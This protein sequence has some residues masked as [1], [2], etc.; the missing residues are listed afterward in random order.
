MLINAK[1]V[2]KKMLQLTGIKILKKSGRTI[3]REQKFLN[4]SRQMSKLTVHGEQKTE[5]EELHTMPWLEPSVMAV[6]FDYPASDV[7]KKN[8]LPIMKITT[9]LL[10]LFGSVNLVTNKDTKKSTNY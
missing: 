4:V 3:G 6:Y 9:N 7:K 5:G 1:N 8:P 10:K 2:T